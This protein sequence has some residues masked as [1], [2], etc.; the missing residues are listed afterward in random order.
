MKN[1][2]KEIIRL[3]KQGDNIAYKY[4]YDYYYVLLCAIAYEYLQDD[5]LAESIVGDLIFNL[6]EKRETIEIT[7]SLRCYL[8][9][10]VRNRSI[11]Y[12]NL[13]RE[14][15]EITFSSVDIGQKEN[16]FCSETFDYPLA[17]LLE[18]ELEE[19]IA[20]AIEN[21]PRDC[22]RIFK[23]S[24][25][26]DKRYEQIASE[27]GVSVNTVKYHIKNALQRLNNDLSKYLITLYFIYSILK[28]YLNIM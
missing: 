11:N 3:L 4:I 8:I 23:M 14:K 18:N 25:F 5:F 28:N 6:W 20:E 22:S 7:T 24:R 10:S 27:L 16:I 13:E 15:R 12:L 17:K 2:E 26:E 21:L 19:K 1:N 9:R